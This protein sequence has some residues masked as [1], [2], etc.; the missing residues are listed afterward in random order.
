MRLLVDEAFPPY[1]Y[2]P[3]MFPHPLSDPNGHGFEIGPEDATE[4]DPTNWPRCRAYLRG[5]DLFN[6]GYYWESHECW[7][8]VWHNAGRHGLLADFL[9]ALIKIAAALVKAREG[10]VDGVRRHA[11]RALEL[12]SFTSEQV[13]G[14]TFMGLPLQKLVE[15]AESIAAYPERYLNT[16]PDPV[17]RLIPFEWV[18]SSMPRHESDA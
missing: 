9:K 12:L 16:S 1:S 11:R 5:L 8:A 14:N 10:R 18:P 2:V 3:G 15:A 6:H 7:E 4:T 17:V 13:T